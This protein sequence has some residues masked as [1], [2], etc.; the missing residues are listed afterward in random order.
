MALPPTVA[1]MAPLFA[2]KHEMV[3]VGLNVKLIFIREFK[4]MIACVTVTQLLASDTTM[5]YVPPFKF[6]AIDVVLTLGDQVKENGAVPLLTTIVTVALPVTQSNPIS[7]TAPK[8]E[9]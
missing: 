6:V 4:L 8:P 3:F 7:G 9:H 5:L 2:P 1:V